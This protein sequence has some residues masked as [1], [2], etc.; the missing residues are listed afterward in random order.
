MPKA[1]GL[2][3]RCRA[4]CLL[5][6]ILLGPAAGAADQGLVL[7]YAFDEDS[8]DVARD[9]SGHGNE[10]KISGATFVP[11]GD[12][13]ALRFDK[14][15]DHVDCGE[16]GSL[17]MSKA[18]TL[19]MWF[20]P[21]AVPAGETALLSKE[22]AYTIT[23]YQHGGMW[24]YLAGSPGNSSAR[25]SP[26]IPANVWHH[27][28]ATYDG[29]EMK[30][31]L[32]GEVCL[33]S[34]P[35]KTK[36]I[37]AGGKLVL[38]R[39]LPKPDD[40]FEGLV[41]ESFKGLMDDVRIHNRAFSE[42]EAQK[43]YR[44]TLP[45]QIEIRP[46]V[47]FFAREL[48]VQLDMRGLAQRGPMIPVTVEI[49]DGATK[50]VIER[51][52]IENVA[53][54]GTTEVR[55][56]PTLL[57]EGREYVVHAEAR[58]R[59]AERLVGSGSASFTWPKRPAW[60]G[61]PAQPRV[62]NAL[63]TE[64]LSVTAQEKDQEE[65]V[66]FNPRDGWVFFSSLSSAGGKGNLQIML[67]D[68]D[69][70]LIEQ[71]AG[72]GTME[73]MR[74]LSKGEYRLKVKVEGPSRLRRLV[75]RAIP[76]LV[77]AKAPARPHT[78]EYGAYNWNFLAKDVVPNVNVVV[79]GG[80]EVEMRAW[81]SQGRQTIHQCRVVGI[82]DMASM[83]PEE[84][85]E[86]YAK[87]PGLSGPLYDGV[88]ADEINYA[89]SSRSLGTTA[90][91]EILLPE[92][93]E[94]FRGRHFNIYTG[95][96]AGHYGARAHAREFL[97]V[98]AGCGGHFYHERYLDTPRTEAE[99]RALL[100]NR[101]TSLMVAARRALPGAE[102][103]AGICFG[104]FSAPP[105]SL[106]WYADVDY[107]VWLEMQFRTVATQADFFGLY[108][109]MTYLSDY[110]DEEVVRWAG[111]LMR[112]YCI[113]GKTERLSSDPYR[114]PH[115]ANPDFADGLTGWKVL[116][117]EDGSI[118]PAKIEGFDELRGN[119]GHGRPHDTMAVMRRSASKPNELRQT[120][121]NL[122]PG[123]MYSLRFYAA[124][125]KDMIE[126]VTAQKKL[127]VSARIEGVQRV[128]EKCFVHVEATIHV[129]AGFSGK[130]KRAYMNF[131]RIVFRAGRESSRLALS[132]WADQ[133]EAGGPPGQETIF[134]FIQVQPYLED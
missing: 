70:V 56:D 87:M 80:P 5:F 42:E 97:A 4:V 102:R 73:A 54:D 48:I 29:S 106:D 7:H 107:R 67:S 13:F 122:V 30:L 53:T 84:A 121:R 98:V 17:A 60:E 62:L 36:E 114:L 75:V 15:G 43:L 77:Y 83:S 101:L 71:L 32:D 115:L 12:G 28:V 6:A 45:P 131:H 100:D 18:L 20:W 103:T 66:F 24:F 25:S 109:I 72:R 61:A 38:G 79:S 14:V 124:D 128:P 52:M 11:R 34:H 134:S 113:E 90:A 8:G 39:I 46:Y 64:L 3:Y 31:Y 120:I 132:D 10:G 89:G 110:A 44:E 119:W 33:Q 126:T 127:A 81:K 86:F 1:D 16:D 125:Y 82:Q 23:F 47:Y 22:R 133:D 112:H 99:G 123:R 111:R 85:A 49:L 94:K 58:T 88:I 116:P 27:L 118:F 69:E 51:K 40:Q 50:E 92:W 2:T 63:V 59:S 9:K 91:L 19:S 41:G 37:S 95:G 74:L 55:V 57:V 78:R 26:V 105:E 108:G 65:H 117:A 35:C 130:E 96:G 104:Y 21:D 93:K 76:E 129:G 68:S